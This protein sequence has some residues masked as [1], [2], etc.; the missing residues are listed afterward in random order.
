MCKICD[1]L[2]KNLT[3][4]NIIKTKH[5]GPQGENF[6]RLGNKNMREGCCRLYYNNKTFTL[7]IFCIDYDKAYDKWWPKK[8]FQIYSIYS[9]M[10]C[11]VHINYGN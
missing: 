5:I 8:E 1:I 6:Y 7:K 3:I 10:V 4:N 9:L 11:K 2:T